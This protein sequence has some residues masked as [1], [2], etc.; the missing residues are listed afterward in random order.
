M[1]NQIENRYTNKR[2]WFAFVSIFPFPVFFLM[3]ILWSSEVVPIVLHKGDYKSGEFWPYD[4]MSLPS[5][6]GNAVS[7]TVFGIVGGVRTTLGM[8]I[9]RG[10]PPEVYVPDTAR[11]KQIEF[12]R[13]WYREDGENT[14]LRTNRG[15]EADFNDVVWRNL[16]LGGLLMA[17]LTITF[18]LYLY[19][20]RKERLLRALDGNR[21]EVP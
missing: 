16:G 18:S 4:R 1:S 17:P 2:F 19:Y 21:T 6:S 9:D 11:V 3:G 7:E 15:F 12:Y 20:R 14:L 13:V 10:T 8:P 5:R